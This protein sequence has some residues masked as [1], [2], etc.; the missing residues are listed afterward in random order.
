LKSYKAF[1]SIQFIIAFSFASLFLAGSLSCGRQETAETTLP[2]N[3]PPHVVSVRVLPENPNPKSVFNLLIESYDPDSDRVL[4]RYQWL[5]NDEGIAGEN[6]E[7]LRGID[8]KMGDL[9]RV[10]VIPSDGKVEGEPFLS[11]PVK[12]VLSPEVI[13]ELRIEPKIAYSNCDLKVF[14]KSHETDGGSVSYSYKW[15]KNGVVLPEEKTDVLARGRFK[16]GDAIAVTATPQGV[17]SEGMPR[18]SEPITIANGPPIITSSPPQKINGNIYTYQ[19]TADDPD[20]DPIVFTLKAAPKGMEIDKETGLVRWEVRKGD[21]GAQPVEIQAS[22]SEGAKSFQR[23]TLS[24][25]LR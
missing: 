12:I 6:T 22:D 4:Y 3:S 15:E 8:L 18:K 1:S 25:E 9:I 13:E 16:R 20:N 21:Q 2:K 10:K 14:V 24:V 23:Y 11:S 19:V 5:K 17:E 7:I